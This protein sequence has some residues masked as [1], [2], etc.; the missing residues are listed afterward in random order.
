MPAKDVGQDQDHHPDPDHPDEEDDHRPQ[1]V[2]EWI[3][4]GDRH[5]GRLLWRAVS[6]VRADPRGEQGEPTSPFA[7]ERLE[8]KGRSATASTRAPAWVRRGAARARLWSRA[9]TR[10]VVLA[11]AVGAV[12]RAGPSCRSA[13]CCRSVRLAAVLALGLD[14]VVGALVTRGW[15]RGRAALVVLAGAVRR[16]CSRSS[17]SPRGRCG[18]RSRSSPRR[19]RPTGTTSATD[20]FQSV[21]RA[22]NF[23]DKVR[24]A[25]KDFAAALPDTADDDPRDRRRHLRLDPV[26][27]DADV[28]LPV[29][30]DGAADDH[31]LA[32]RL[33]AAGSGGALAPGAGA[34]DHRRVLV[35]DRQRRDLRRRSDRGGVVGV[36][37]RAALPPGARASSPACS[38]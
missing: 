34:L 19:C 28:P 3:V 35:A 30:A 6:G 37:V 17:S 10:R 21:T 13:R 11:A 4:S 25:L 16:R 15:K 23:D 22:A 2:E 27:G 20:W 33:H 14:P 5:V 29:P 26:A 9:R 12:V 8:K 38:T 24:D 36:G 18:T 1:D 32:V 31:R 7:G